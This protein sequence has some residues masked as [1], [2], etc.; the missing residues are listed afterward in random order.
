MPSSSTFPKRV[1]TINEVE[2]ARKLVKA[3][4]KH[5]ILIKGSPTFKRKTKEALKHIK[6][7]Q[8][9]NFLRSYIHRIIEIDGFSQLRETEAA[10]WTNTHLLE[11]TV[12]AAGFIIQK[13]HQ[14]KEFLEGKL[15]YG[16]AAEARSIDQRIQFL[17]TLEKQSKNPKIKNKCRQLLD[18]WAESASSVGP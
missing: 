18:M 16:G 4:Y 1:Y 2:E 12:E 6:T 14:M 13:T 11:D 8:L 10:I 17:N 5:R 15:Y 9:Y 7:A 3:G